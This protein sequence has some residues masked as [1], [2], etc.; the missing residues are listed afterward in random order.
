MA[1]HSSFTQCS[2]LH[3]PRDCFDTQAT[4]FQVSRAC[5]V[6]RGDCCRNAARGIGNACLICA[7]WVGIIFGLYA[8]LG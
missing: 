4:L 5:G 6:E 1:D 3:D 8:V 7:C 2:A